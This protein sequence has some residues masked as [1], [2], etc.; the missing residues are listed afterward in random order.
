MIPHFWKVLLDGHGESD[1]GDAITK[2][3]EII[4][5]WSFVED[6]FYTFTPDG[7]EEQIFFESSLGMLCSR[8]AELQEGKGS[9]QF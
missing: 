2:D 1:T 6:V 5:M 4:G 7:A 8:I 3:G 9:S